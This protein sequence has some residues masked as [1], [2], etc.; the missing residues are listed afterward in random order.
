[1]RGPSYWTAAEREYLG[2]VTSEANE[3]PFCQ[4]IHTETTWRPTIVTTE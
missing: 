3:C 2:M 4:R 1:M